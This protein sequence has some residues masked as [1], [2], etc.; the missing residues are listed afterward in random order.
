[1]YVQS[2]PYP[3][4][5]NHVFFFPEKNGSETASPPAWALIIS[6]KASKSPEAAARCKADTLGFSSQGDDDWGY[7]SPYKSP[8][9][10]GVI[11]TPS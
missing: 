7:L 3:S 8:P 6:W 2:F 5:K 1:M 10:N 4:Q 11:Y 9:K